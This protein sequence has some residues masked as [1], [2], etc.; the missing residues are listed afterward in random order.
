MTGRQLRRL[1]EDLGMTTHAFAD[2][3]GVH[4]STL[5]RWEDTEIALKTDPLQ[6]KIIERLGE[7]LGDMSIE[8]RRALGKKVTDLLLAKG[9]L[10]ALG[11]LIAKIT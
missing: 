5:Y 7:E 11:G 8:Q 10:V 9:S 1:R 3:I 4:V 6:Q 2:V